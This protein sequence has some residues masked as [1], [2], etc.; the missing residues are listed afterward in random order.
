VA[1]DIEERFEVPVPVGRV[2][3]TLVDLRHLVRCLPGTEITGRGENESVRLQTTLQIG[4]TA[5]EYSGAG[6]LTAANRGEHLVMLRTAATSEDGAGALSMQA[7]IRAE[8]LPEL[9]T[10]VTVSANVTLGASAEAEAGEAAEL[11]AARGFVR[12]FTDG[13]ERLIG[14]GPVAVDTPPVAA[15]SLQDTLLEIKASPRA[16]ADAEEE[17]PDAPALSQL[18]HTGAIPVMQRPTGTRA[19]EAAAAAARASAHARSEQSSPGLAG[20][21]ASWFSRLFGGGR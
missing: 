11:E 21:L 5:V 14:G 17:P 1:F 16:G 10:V 20:A 19:D 3:N 12:G 13:L 18:Q 6:R 7:R 15:S 8:P 4:T 9:G 2:Y